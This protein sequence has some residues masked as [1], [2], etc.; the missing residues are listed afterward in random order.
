MSNL[1]G[2]SPNQTFFCNKHLSFPEASFSGHFV[3]N[4]VLGDMMTV[5]VRERKYVNFLE[6][7]YYHIYSSW[8]WRSTRAR[9]SFP[10]F[11]CSLTVGSVENLHLSWITV[12]NKTSSQK[13]GRHASHRVRSVWKSLARVSFGSKKF[14]A[15]IFLLIFSLNW[16][17]LR[18]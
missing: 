8:S 3:V 18:K 7:F 13:L 17:I 1:I 12:R 2:C 4:H 14:G 10:P 5:K 15:K 9:Q 6:I 11:H 16:I